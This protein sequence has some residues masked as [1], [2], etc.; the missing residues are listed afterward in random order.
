M[1]IMPAGVVG[2]TVI[3]VVVGTTVVTVVVVH[4]SFRLQEVLL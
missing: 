4:L 3:P 1:F 2:A